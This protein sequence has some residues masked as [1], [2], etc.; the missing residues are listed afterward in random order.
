MSTLSISV[1][2]CAIISVIAFL[3]TTENVSIL[4]AG[5]VTALAIVTVY[6]LIV[7]PLLT[8][9]RRND[10]ESIMNEIFNQFNCPPPKVLQENAMPKRRDTVSKLRNWF[11]AVITCA[12]IYFT[13]NIIY[14]F[15][16]CGVQCVSTSVV[17]IYGIP[18][19]REVKSLMVYSAI[20]TIQ[21][22][23]F[24]MSMLHGG[25]MILFSLLITFEFNEAFISLHLNFKRAICNTVDRRYNEQLK[26]KTVSDLHCTELFE[27]EKFKTNLEILVKHHR[28]FYR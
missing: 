7:L 24:W 18:Y 27:Y 5:N 21:M 2:Y 15:F 1:I 22:I 20:Y 4:E 6:V 17:Y 23:P 28:N 13:S 14:V 11:I 8:Y 25:G 9:Y 26:T 16:F 19:V 10:I 3:A 12:I